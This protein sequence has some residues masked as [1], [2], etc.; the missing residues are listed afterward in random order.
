LTV[1]G[2][3]FV[4]GSMVLWN[5][6]GLAA[7]YIS[8]TQLTAFVTADL[9][10]IRAGV[11]ANVTVVN[12]GGAASNSVT[13]TIE[14]AHPTILSLSP[15]S[16]AAGSQATAIGIAGS[17]FAANCVAR[18]NGVAVETTYGDAG[19][20]SVTV[21]ANLLV[22]PGGYSITVT[23]PSGMA[24]APMTFA[25]VPSVPVAGSVSPASATAG[26]PAFTLTVTGAYFAPGSAVLW[27]GSALTTMFGSTTQVS[28]AVPAN[29]VAVVG[30]AS[31]TV[32][33]PGGLISKAV[34]FLV[35]GALPP[36]TPAPAITPGGIVNA[37]SSLPSI[38]PGALISIYGSNLASSDARAPAT[39]LPK[40]LNGT[41]VSINGIPAPLLFVSATQ[42]NAQAPFEIAAGTATVVVHSGTLES[43][44]VKVE[45]R[46]AA[47]GILALAGSHALAVNYPGGAL[48][49]P[50]NP[51]HPGEYVV[52]YLTGQGL[53]D[54]TVPS[55]AESPADPFALPLAP[56]FAKLGGKTA[57]IAF[58]GLAPGFVGLLQINLL[59][60]DIGGGEQA[61]EVSVGDAQ[62]NSTMLSVALNR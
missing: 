45:V 44:A 41:A 20:V 25:V 40:S 48:N 57:E 49:T 6:I 15:G 12:P 21:P 34:P 38:A 46:A 59:V 36:A 51:V 17:N 9:V 28:A 42:I 39:P 18:W 5:G 61:L 26:G 32:S 13:L 27:N 16:A 43:P 54:Q 11:T 52:V 23:N 1:S 30:S 14:P 22:N 10:S 62:A 55:G 19:H 33:N 35:T 60:P 37:F 29:L 31:V 3:G 58:A 47:P 53:V 7:S 2:T 8:G 56:V 24:T 4:S 50:Q